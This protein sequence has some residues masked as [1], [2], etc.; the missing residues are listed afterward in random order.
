M[1]LGYAAMRLSGY[2]A[3]I[4]L[5]S[6]LAIRLSS[7]SKRQG[8]VHEQDSKI[9]ELF[10]ALR[11]Q[12]FFPNMSCLTL[13]LDARNLSDAMSSSLHFMGVMVVVVVVDGC[14]V[15]VFYLQKQKDRSRQC[16]L[17]QLDMSTLMRRCFQSNLQ[18]YRKCNHVLRFLG[19]PFG[20]RKASDETRANRNNIEWMI[21]RT[22]E[23]STN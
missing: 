18:K 15:C 19:K 21:K 17:W 22:S 3:V 23:Q 14:G 9:P 10:F 7:K 20:S 1:L 4:K 13:L 8:S 5:L 11:K 6:Y 12:R 16:E 2:R